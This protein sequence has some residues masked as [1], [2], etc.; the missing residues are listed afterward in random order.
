MKK[1]ENSAEAFETF[2]N[3]LDAYLFTLGEYISGKVK[4]FESAIYDHR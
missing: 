1:Q 4:N 2:S 3:R